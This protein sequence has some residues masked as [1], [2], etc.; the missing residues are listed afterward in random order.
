MGYYQFNGSDGMRT[1]VALTE[2][3]DCANSKQELI[4]YLEYGFSK[5]AKKG[6]PIDFNWMRF[7]SGWSANCGEIY[8]LTRPYAIKIGYKGPVATRTPMYIIVTDKHIV[9]NGNEL[10]PKNVPIAKRKLVL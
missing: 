3:P 4:E 5:C 8:V 2:M 7:F 9:C 6:I 1:S 10:E